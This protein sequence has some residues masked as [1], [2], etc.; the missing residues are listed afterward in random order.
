MTCRWKLKRLW[1]RSH[2][3]RVVSC[4]GI[5]MEAPFLV[6]STVHKCGDT[7]S[8][9]FFD[10]ISSGFSDFLLSI[11]YKLL[12]GRS[13]GEDVMMYSWPNHVYCPNCVFL[14]KSH[15]TSPNYM[16]LKKLHVTC[17]NFVLFDQI[18]LLVQITCYLTKSYVTCLNYELLAQ[19]RQV[20]NILLLTKVILHCLH[21][22]L[23][24]L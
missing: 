16:Y 11:Y 21:V 24:Y 13:H 1:T 9:A 22:N 17:P 4:R 14:T 15:V 3:V 12:P 18:T 7:T 20:F 5:M 2:Q 10:V 8:Y 23:P 19:T 6:R